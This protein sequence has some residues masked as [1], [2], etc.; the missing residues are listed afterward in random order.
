MPA[1]GIF[2][3]L[4]ERER[5]AFIAL[6]GRVQA[7]LHQLKEEPSALGREWRIRR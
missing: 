7:Q 4:D 2:A 6:L 5:A 1:S 3:V